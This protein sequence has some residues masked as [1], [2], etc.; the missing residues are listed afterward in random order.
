MSYEI[1]AN[2]ILGLQDE[3][4]DTIRFSAIASEIVRDTVQPRDRPRQLRRVML[5]C[6]E[7]SPTEL[8]YSADVKHR[9]DAVGQTLTRDGVVYLEV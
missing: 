7:N 9:Q 8:T 3:T 5:S 1:C 6:M 4:I 2:P